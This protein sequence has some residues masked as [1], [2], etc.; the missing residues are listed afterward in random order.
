MRIKFLFRKRL[1]FLKLPER[2][3]L[4]TV[5]MLFKNLITVCDEDS[6]TGIEDPVIF[7]FNHSSHYETF[8]IGSYLA[9]QRCGKKIS[10]IID[11]MFRYLPVAG[12]II[13]RSDPVYVY[14]KTS[15]IGLLNRFFKPEAVPKVYEQCIKLIS[16][17]KS[18]GIFPEGTVNRDPFFLKKG[19]SGAARIVLSTNA[20]VLPIGIDFPRKGRKTPA[21]GPIIFR[22]GKKM[23]FTEYYDMARKL[24]ESGI[25]RHELQLSEAGIMAV[26]THKIMCE[27][28]RLSGKI[29]PYELTEYNLGGDYVKIDTGNQGREN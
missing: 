8:L 4:R 29:Y 1:P 27:I 23:N 12:W 11:W 6:L 16:E 28:S 26:I 22:I 20:P 17:K 24:R 21:F 3:A 15:T 19:K 13:G 2:M 10:F 18:L 5:L 7:V 14:N 25:S 9:F